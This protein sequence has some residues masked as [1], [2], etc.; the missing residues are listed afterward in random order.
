MAETKKPAAK[1]AAVQKA[2]VKKAPVKKAAAPKAEAKPAEEVAP[3]AAPAKK[4]R[5]GNK[6]RTHSTRLLDRYES[7]IRPALLS[8][9]K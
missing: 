9:F 5:K 1:S 3:K 2:P 6:K 7:E 8:E 4:V